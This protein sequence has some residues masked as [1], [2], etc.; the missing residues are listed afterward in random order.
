MALMTQEQFEESLKD[1]KPRVF[2]N[3]TK[4]ENNKSKGFS[5]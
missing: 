1:F 3:G 4:V 5:R 2:M